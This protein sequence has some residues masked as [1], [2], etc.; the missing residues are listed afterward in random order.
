MQSWKSLFALLLS[1]LVATNSE[2]ANF[3]RR[4]I[5]QWGD[6]FTLPQT[7]L[8]CTNDSRGDLPG[9]GE[10]KT[11]TG[12]TVDYQT[13]QVAI[14]AKAIGPDGLVQAAA[15]AVADVA[16]TCTG[17]A[18]ASAVGAIVAA[19]SPEPSVRIAA[20]YAIGTQTFSTCL[21]NHAAELTAFGVGTAALKLAF[22]LDS[23]WSNWSNEGRIPDFVVGEVPASDQ[24]A[25][26]E[27]RRHVEAATIA[28]IMLVL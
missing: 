15:D 9:G 2:A 4:K 1:L 5:A 12:W 16:K 18:V 20:G 28:S 22:D 14:Y 10:W 7:R 26:A 24:E 17:I 11:C 8:R 3:G 6:P 13:M 27:P 21:A 25:L 23:F 19:P